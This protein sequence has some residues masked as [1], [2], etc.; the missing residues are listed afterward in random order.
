MAHTAGSVAGVSNSANAANGFVAILDQNRKV[1][2]WEC[3]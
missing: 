3:R 2:E 1:D